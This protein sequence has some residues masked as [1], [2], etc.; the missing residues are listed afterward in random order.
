MDPSQ[1]TVELGTKPLPVMLSVN[2]PLPVLTRSGESAA[3]VGTGLPDT[4]DTLPRSTFDPP[5]P[6]SNTWISIV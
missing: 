3:I 4:T 5:P 6:R 2:P 1:R